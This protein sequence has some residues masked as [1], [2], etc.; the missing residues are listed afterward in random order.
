MLR[1]AWALVV[2]VVALPALLGG[3]KRE[4]GPNEPQLTLPTK[5]KNTASLLFVGDLSVARGIS[6]AIDKDGKG[7]TAWPFERVKPLFDAHDLVFANLECVVSDSDAEEAV[8]KTYRIKALPKYLTNLH[9]AGVDVVSVANNHAMDFGA[10]G[11]ASTIATLKKEGVLPVGA[12]KKPGWD[13]DVVIVDVG[14]IRVGFLAYNQHGDEYKHD[15]WRPTSMRYKIGDVVDD[16]KAARP[17]VDFL[18]VSVHGGLELSHEVD[19]WQLKDAHAAIDAG[20]D[21]WVGHHP[22]VAQPY[23]VYKGKLITYSL[24]DF[25][26]DKSS[27]WLVER[28]RPRFFLEMNLTKDAGGKVTA[29][30]QLFTG[31]Q[32]TKTYRPFIAEKF[33]DVASFALPTTKTTTFRDLLKDARVE[34]VR[35]DKEGKDV[36]GVCSRWE[37]RRAP[38]NGHAFRWLAPRWGCADDAKA[39]AKRA[40]ESVAPTAE[41]FQSSLKRGIWA[42]PNA[43]GPLRIRFPGVQLNDQL[44]GFAGVPDWGVTL[45]RQQEAKGK[46]KTPPVTLKLSLVDKDGKAL[47]ESTLDAP[48]EPGTLP[49]ALDTSKLKGQ[50]VDVVAEVSGGSGDAEG[51]FVF[52]LQVQP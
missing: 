36:V 35:R 16:I 11:F 24:G 46:P 9:D 40:W 29:T 47:L 20:A 6:E 38:V 49:I 45:S 31:D 14:G 39:D 52:D 28:N 3:C 50:R 26:F 30:H 18:V 17:K 1:M 43:G 23:E 27:P 37:R 44:T 32:E 10:Q 4:P 41:L 13:H 42:H 22:H 48:C 51:R 33:F 12:Q 2:V 7:D 15:D 21:V 8:S 25:L 19:A 34:R 5:T